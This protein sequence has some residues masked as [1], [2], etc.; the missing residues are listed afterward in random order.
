LKHIYYG[1]TQD[2]NVWCNSYRIPSLELDLRYASRNMRDFLKERLEEY[3]ETGRGAYYA[4]KHRYDINTKTFIAESEHEYVCKVGDGVKI[5]NYK[6]NINKIEYDANTDTMHCYTDIVVS[7][8]ENEDVEKELAEKNEEIR[9]QL[10]ELYD[11][12]FPKPEK[13][14]TLVELEK[15]REEKESKKPKGFWAWLLGE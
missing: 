3:L 8:L 2:T 11:K 7:V 10:Q 6:G 13:P 5:K 14:K 12:F 1:V 15:E 9:K 4:Y